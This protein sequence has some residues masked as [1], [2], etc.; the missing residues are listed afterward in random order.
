MSA[1]PAPRGWINVPTEGSSRLVIPVDKIE[2]VRVT[3]STM[4]VDRPAAVRISMQSGDNWSLACTAAE[5]FNKID[6][7]NVVRLPDGPFPEGDDDGS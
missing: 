5:L 6:M 4:I 1:H 7:A 2:S 3:P